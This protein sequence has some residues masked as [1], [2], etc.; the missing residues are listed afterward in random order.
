KGMFEEELGLELYQRYVAA[1]H[2]AAAEVGAI[3]VEQ[4]RETR[5]PLFT[6]DQYQAKHKAQFE[7]RG[8]EAK[9]EDLSHMN[10]A[11]GRLVARDIHRAHYSGAKEE[12]VST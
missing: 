5:G 7:Q 1:A 4:P 11:Y 6:L 3:F 8:G 9:A 2:L 12:A 10:S